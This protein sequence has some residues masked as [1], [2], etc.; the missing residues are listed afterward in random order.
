MAKKTKDS[1]YT[2]QCPACG[3]VYQH[4]SRSKICTNNNCGNIAVMPPLTDGAFEKAAEGE[5]VEAP[6]KPKEKPV[7]NTTGRPPE[8]GGEVF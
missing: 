7:E 8:K 6:A 4:I 1:Y 5:T 3:A 2:L